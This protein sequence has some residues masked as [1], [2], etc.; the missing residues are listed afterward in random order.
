MNYSVSDTAEYGGL[1]VGPK[2][3]TEATKQ[4]MR[5]QLKRIQSGEFAKEWIDE[6]QS[7][8]K[9]FQRLRDAEANHPV[10]KVGAEL[11]RMMPWI[12]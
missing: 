11:R 6:F 12:K 9:I 7:G 3:V 5:D 2:I 8:G 1:S 10:E 4:V